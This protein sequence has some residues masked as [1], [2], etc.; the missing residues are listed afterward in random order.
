[1]AATTPSADPAIAAS[2]GGAVADATAWRGVIPTACRTWRSATVA[3]VYLATDWPIRKIAATSA[4]SAK[5]NRQAASYRVILSISPPKYWRL[6]QHVDVGPAGHPGQVGPERGDGRGA[7]LQPDQ[8]V[9]EVLPVGAEDVGAVLREQGRRRQHAALARGL[10]HGRGAKTL[11]PMPTMRALIRGPS[12]G[13]VDPSYCSFDLLGR[14][15]VQ[16]YGIA[17]VLAV[18]GRE[19]R[20]DHD[21]VD[22]GGVEHPS[23]QQ[24]RPFQGPGHF[25]V[26]GREPGKR[27]RAA[28][29]REPEHDRQPG[30]RG[31]LGQGADLIPV[32]PGLVGQHGHGRGQRAVPE[33][34]ERG[35]PAAGPRGRREH[36]RRGQRH[37]QGEH[38]QRPP[39]S[40]PLQ[41][42]PGHGDAH[43]RPL[44]TRCA[45]CARCAA[46]P[47]GGRA[48]RPAGWRPAGRP[49][50]SA[51]SASTA[52]GGW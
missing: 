13:P 11:R 15:Q 33:P 40:P 38:E 24:G 34:P 35:L 10:V 41:A 48:R 1:M 14:G 18:G 32:E 37:Q 26:D 9:D 36:R 2:S 44:L 12:G 31:H 52:S 4:A 30:Q 20:G 29:Q 45:G 43:A 25:V 23:G 8:R 3:E 19:L 5:A 6:F 27:V 42:Q 50:R 16:G 17:D 49:A 7:A 47:R 28:V 51:A 21:L 39:A 22:A 46:G